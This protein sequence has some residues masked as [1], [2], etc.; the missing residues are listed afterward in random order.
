MFFSHTA[1]GLG[2]GWGPGHRITFLL[3]CGSLT[4]VVFVLSENCE[5]LPLLAWYSHA[6]RIK[7]I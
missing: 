6:K 1:G 2:Q 3:A 4:C 5:I 7:S